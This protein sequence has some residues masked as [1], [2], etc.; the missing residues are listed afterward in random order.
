MKNNNNQKMPVRIEEKE[1]YNNIYA[2]QKTTL[3]VEKLL[4]LFFYSQKKRKKKKT[5]PWVFSE[6]DAEA[7]TNAI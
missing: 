2:A 3:R 4:R 6:E 1:A 7:L 5:L